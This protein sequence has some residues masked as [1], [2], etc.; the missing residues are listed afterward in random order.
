MTTVMRIDVNLTVETEDGELV[1][2]SNARDVD[3][4]VEEN[5]T[6]PLKRALKDGE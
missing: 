1:E 5:E 4:V 6:T 3:M 2:L